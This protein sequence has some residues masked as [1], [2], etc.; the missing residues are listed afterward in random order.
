[1]VD[2]GKSLSIDLINKAIIDDNYNAKM[3]IDKYSVIDAVNKMYDF[4]NKYMNISIVKFFKCLVATAFKPYITQLILNNNL[5]CV[6]D[7]FEKNPN[8]KNMIG[9]IVL[10]IFM[11]INKK[12][13]CELAKHLCDKFESV[14]PYLLK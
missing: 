5:D 1:M 7:V 3:F 10:E 4:K 11:I 8:K 2:M 13:L 6:I 12:G 14:H 9:S